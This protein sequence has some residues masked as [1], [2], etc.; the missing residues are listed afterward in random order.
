M[1]ILYTLNK[2]SPLIG[3]IV[4]A[5]GIYFYIR[6]IKS[7]GESELRKKHTDILKKEI[8]EPWIKQLE[9]IGKAKKGFPP[10]PNYYYKGN[11][12]SVEGEPLF[13]DMENHVDK[14][15]FKTY[16]R[17]KVNC[18]ELSHKSEDLQEKLYKF[19][20]TEYEFRD[21]FKFSLWEYFN[22]ENK[23]TRKPG[24]FNTPYSHPGMDNV[25]GSDTLNFFLDSLLSGCSH[26]I[27]N[28][29]HNSI[30]SQDE[31]DVL[32][33]DCK[34]NEFGEYIDRSITEEKETEI[35]TKINRTL[36]EI[37]IE[38]K[39][40]IDEIVI[41]IDNINEE[42]SEVLKNL[43]ERSEERRV[44]KECRSRWSPYH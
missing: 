10:S 40:E 24:F 32:S 27:F 21:K 1:D 2:Y 28:M 18:R 17:F 16:K 13:N 42:R 12:I 34:R 23:E 30:G 19:L 38:F 43:E 4:A 20:V 5:L 35:K 29:S 3:V 6:E 7:G 25:L 36:K 37:K 33:F 44:G 11:D 31:F 15:L 39:N 14:K 8:V 26:V 41:L 9:E 22:K